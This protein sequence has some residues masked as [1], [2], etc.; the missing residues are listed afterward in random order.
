MSTRPVEKALTKCKQPTAIQFNG[1]LTLLAVL[2]K[3]TTTHQE[4]LP[5]ADGHTFSAFWP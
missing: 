4:R 5:A 1:C 2:I 3:F